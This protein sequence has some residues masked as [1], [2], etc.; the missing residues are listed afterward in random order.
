MLCVKIIKNSE[1]NA[2]LMFKYK[3]FPPSFDAC[4]KYQSAD[5][6]YEIQTTQA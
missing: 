6:I 3:K 1:Y 5:Y 2:K 4:F